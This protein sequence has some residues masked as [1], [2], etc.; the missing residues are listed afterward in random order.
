MT[1]AC[2]ICGGLRFSPGPFGR[3]SIRGLPPRCTSCGSLERHRVMHG[4]IAGLRDIDALAAYR[5]IRFSPDRVVDDRWFASAEISI[6]EGENS[7]DIQS[8]DRPDESYDVVIC[9]HVLEHVQDDE[10]AVKELIRILS[11]RGFLVLAVPR[12]ETGRLTSDWGFADPARN[13]HYRGYGYDFDDRLVCLAD[14][15]RVFAID[16]ADP[17]TGDRKRFHI[18]TK[19]EVWAGRLDERAQKDLSA[20]DPV[21]MALR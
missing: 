21:I 7:L 17:V 18:V 5:L 9:S 15:A 16:Q 10:R 19:S 4:F 20:A 8:I 1:A 13:L 3:L 14:G 2:S 11:P 6:Y 12:V